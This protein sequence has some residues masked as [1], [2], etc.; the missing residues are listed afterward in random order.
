MA[1]SS[2]HTQGVNLLL[3]DGSVRFISNHIEIGIWQALATR[4]GSEVVENKF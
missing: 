2:R 3:A 4:K 1:A